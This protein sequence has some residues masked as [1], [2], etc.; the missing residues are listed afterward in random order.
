MVV[1]NFH[2]FAYAVSY[3]SCIRCFKT[4]TNIGR[5]ACFNN[6][7]RLIYNISYRII[8][9]L[10]IHITSPSPHAS[11]SLCAYEHRVI[12]LTCSVYIHKVPCAFQCFPRC[13]I[14]ICSTVSALSLI[15]VAYCPCCSVV[16]RKKRCC[17]CAVSPYIS[18]RHF[19]Y[20][21]IWVLHAY[22]CQCRIYLVCCR[23]PWRRVRRNTKTIPFSIN[24]NYQKACPALHTGTSYCNGFF[25]IL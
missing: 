12:I 14:V 22:I 9:N 2:I 18:L 6:F 16:K 21:P 11:V 4:L 7:S 5:S 24:C 25:K 10:T 19:N 23:S 20:F 1:I 15:A 8:A 13:I 3:K 17:A